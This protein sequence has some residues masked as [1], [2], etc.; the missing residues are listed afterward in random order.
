MAYVSTINL[1]P[2][3]DVLGLSNLEMVGQAIVATKKQFQTIAYSIDDAISLVGQGLEGS[4]IKVWGID[5]FTMGDIERLNESGLSLEYWHFEGINPGK[6]YLTFELP[7]DGAY[8]IRRIEDIDT[9]T[10]HHSV[11]WGASR[12]NQENIEN[13]ANYHVRTKDWPGIGYHYII[14]PNGEIAQVN[15]LDRKSYHV[16]GQ[17]HHAI[18]ICYGGDFRY[19]QPTQAAIYAGQALVRELQNSLPRHLSIVPHKRME[20]AATACP[21]INDLDLWLKI[22]AR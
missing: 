2:N 22:V 10:I 16:A 9:V 13:I 5:L 15:D 3:I 7:T 17:N 19:T 18:G 11:G 21:G 4:K 12:T 1:I 6:I 20:D 14:S 8:Q